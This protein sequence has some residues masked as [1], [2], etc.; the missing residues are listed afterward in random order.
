MTDDTPDTPDDLRAA[1]ATLPDVAPP[2]RL[3]HQIVAA[4]AL[5]AASRKRRRGWGERL[6]GHPSLIGYGLGLAAATLLFGGL[7]GQVWRQ[8]LTAPPRYAIVYA[9]HRFVGGLTAPATLPRL[10]SDKG[11]DSLPASLADRPDGMLV[12]AE[13]SPSGEARCVDIVEP[14]PTPSLVA[15]VDHA[16]QRMTFRP[17]TQPDGRPVAARIVFYIEQVA[18][19]G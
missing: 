1:L 8:D 5:E 13:V 11:F 15:A 19:R 6:A 12:I 4:L 17:A 2:T 18:V 10:T 7:S 16:L 9:P 14:Q 3:R